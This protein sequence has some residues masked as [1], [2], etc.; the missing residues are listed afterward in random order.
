MSDQL[1]KGL[2]ALAL[3][4]ISWLVKDLVFRLFS[5]RNEK[6]HTELAYRLTQVW[7]PLF[8]WSG[9]IKFQGD[10]RGWSKH[11]LKELENIL[12][13]N[14]H[15]I[16]LKHYYNL[17][18]LIEEATG[19]PTGQIS[20]EDLEETRS[21]VYRQV[22]VLNFIL[23][24]YQL[25]VDLESFTDP[26]VGYKAALRYAST[27]VF[28]LAIWLLIFSILV[29]LVYFAF[30]CGIM[31]PGIILAVLFLVIVALDLQKRLKIHRE[32]QKRIKR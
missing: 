18:K 25:V 17:I 24:K 27:I 5:D 8:Y 11:G 2:I 3:G 30:W 23:F 29:S 19:Q 12:S 6:L 9:I 7:S 32:V 15:I 16:P 20:L 1:E 10:V 22:E 28:H 13:T 31:W 26:F 4:L 21:F 14:A